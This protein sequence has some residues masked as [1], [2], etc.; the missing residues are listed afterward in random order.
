ML[1]LPDKSN[2]TDKIPI[3]VL[4][5]EM[6]WRVAQAKFIIVIVHD[7]NGV[8]M[9]LWYEK[10]MNDIWQSSG[11]KT[12]GEP[13]MEVALRE[14]EE[15]I[16]LVAEP[17]DL[18]FLLNNPNYNCNVYTLKVHPNTELDLIEPNK[19]RKWEKFS[20]EAY[21][22]M[23]RKGCTI[24]IHIT[25]IELILYRIKPKSQTPKWKTTKQAQSKRILQRPRFDENKNEAYMMEM[26]EEAK[27][28]NYR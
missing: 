10:I 17:E 14:L 5:N 20:F 26:A 2:I 13:S 8:R 6:K 28:A 27:L 7:R 25:C 9:S 23:V 15:E 18:K 16:S 21:E 1:R 12:D 22:R 11:G 19:N 24:P 4:R 3:K